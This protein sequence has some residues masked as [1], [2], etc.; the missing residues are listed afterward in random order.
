MDTFYQSECKIKGLLLFFT[1]LYT[2]SVQ[3]GV[4]YM[5]PHGQGV[6]TQG[7]RSQPPNLLLTHFV[8]ICMNKSLKIDFLTVKSGKRVL[9]K[10]VKAYSVI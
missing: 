7:Q 9:G 10:K 4:S 5:H 1:A 8:P 2:L 6:A 3:N